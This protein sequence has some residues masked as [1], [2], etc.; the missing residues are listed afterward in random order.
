MQSLEYIDDYFKGDNLPEQKKTFEERIQT[1]EDFAEEVAF[2]LATIQAARSLNAEDKK[3]RFRE[4]YLTNK[5]RR[6]ANPVKRLWPYLASAAAI[7]TALI[8]GVYLYWQ[9]QTPSQLASEYIHGHFKTMGVQMGSNA[10]NIE[11]GKHLYN[12][13]KYQEALILF[14]NVIQ[15]DASDYYAREYAGIAALQMQNYDKAVMYFKQIEKNTELHVNSGKF[16]HA[17]TLMQRNQPGDDI[18][19][20][21]LLMEVVKE[22]LAGSQQ[23]HEFLKHFN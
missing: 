15:S 5:D 14:E 18:A 19:A 20:K 16:Y 21:S 1:D 13:G 12:E 17:L 22:N 8:V 11:R 7:L 3:E 10:D 23:A 6:R 2:Y 4:L 9:P